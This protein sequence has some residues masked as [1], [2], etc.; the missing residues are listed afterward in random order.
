VW[1]LF[2]IRHPRRDELAREL[3]QRGI[4]TLVH[5]PIALHLQP[6]FASLGGRVGDFPVAERAAGEI[7]SLPLYPEMTDAQAHTVVAA[8]R[9]AA[10]VLA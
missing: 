8:V 4:G 1:H 3:Q 10:A 6:A 5:Y 9:D 2:V 7:L